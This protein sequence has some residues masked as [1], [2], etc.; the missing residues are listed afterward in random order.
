[1]NKLLTTQM[2]L[3]PRVMILF[4]RVM[5]LFPRVMILFRRVMILFPRV[6][7]LVEIRVLSEI[8]F[9]LSDEYLSS[10]SKL[11]PVKSR[12]KHKSESA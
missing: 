6:M 4:P 12:G 8:L 7:R 1:M 9:C 11:D 2:I 10:N 5:I 3:F